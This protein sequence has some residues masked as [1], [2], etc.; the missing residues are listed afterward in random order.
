[1]PPRG[2]KSEKRK[3]QYE[4]IKKSVKA[5][6]G[7]EATASRIAAA[8]TNRTRTAKG[9]TKTT[10][11][12]TA[13]KRAQSGMRAAGRKGGRARKKTSAPRTKRPA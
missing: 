6:G 3:R 8:T 12:P 10:K 5:R 7:S 4:K 1:M 13:R 2:V 9:E 11:S